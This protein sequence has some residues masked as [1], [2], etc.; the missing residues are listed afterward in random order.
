VDPMVPMNQFVAK[1]VPYVAPA[2]KH[3]LAGNVLHPT[4]SVGAASAER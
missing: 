4:R 3:S 1:L 2:K